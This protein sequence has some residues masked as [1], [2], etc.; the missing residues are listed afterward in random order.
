[1][2]DCPSQ[3][4]PKK[5]IDGVAKD[6]IQVKAR[7]RVTV[8]SNLDNYV[9]SALEETVIARVGQAIV[10]AI[11]SAE[12]YKDVLEN[13]DHIARRSLETGLD[14]GTA[15]E[16][17]S[18][19]IADIS[20]AGVATEANVGAKLQAEQAEADKRRFQAEAE[21]RRAMAVAQEQEYQA[22]VQKNR[23]LVVLA[24]AEVPKAM[25][26]AFRSGNLGIMDYYRMRNIQSDTSM[27]SSIA[28]DQNGE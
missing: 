12:T 6:G 24:E 20:V 5:T 18:V 14:T 19:D 9:G 4:G 22:E 15:F 26:D 3:D 13:P 17:L 1:V 23:A 11:G 27:R 28:G 10:S 8:R 2:I 7:A 25:A 16:V 21:K